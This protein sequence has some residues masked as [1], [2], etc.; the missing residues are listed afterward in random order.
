MV[1]GTV[2]NCAAL[3]LFLT[4]TGTSFKGEGKSQAALKNRMYEWQIIL[5]CVKFR[6]S[7]PNETQVKIPF[8]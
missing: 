6:I 2:F 5:N 4:L 7:E 1:G 8:F 3:I